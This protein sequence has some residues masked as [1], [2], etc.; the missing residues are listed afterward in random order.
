MNDIQTM[1]SIIMASR[2]RYVA[3]TAESRVALS[4]A[5]FRAMRAGK[6][7]HAGL[8]DLLIIERGVK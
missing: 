7:R 3:P 6:Y 8:L 2:N 1:D 5:I 4:D